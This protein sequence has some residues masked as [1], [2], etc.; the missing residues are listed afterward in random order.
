VDLFKNKILKINIIM[1]LLFFC[2]LFFVCINA[3]NIQSSYSLKPYSLKPSYNKPTIISSSTFNY[4]Y[5]NNKCYL[6]KNNN[7]DYDYYEENITLLTVNIIYN[8]I[9]YSYI[10]YLLT[11]KH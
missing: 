6:K 7:D 4:N 8:V 10:Y 1:K 11:F 2:N 9:L 3:F 5:N